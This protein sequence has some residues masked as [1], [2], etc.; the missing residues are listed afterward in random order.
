MEICFNHNYLE[1]HINNEYKGDIEYYKSFSE[2]HVKDNL[3]EIELTSQVIYDSLLRTEKG[4]LCI[5]DNKYYSPFLIKWNNETDSPFIFY[6]C[7]KEEPFII[8]QG[9]VYATLHWYYEVKTNMLIRNESRSGEERDTYIIKRCLADILKH[10]KNPSLDLI[11]PK[12]RFYYFGF[13][14]NIGHQ[15]WNE[16]SGLLYLI[17]NEELLKNISKIIIGPVDFFG[18]EKV[19]KDKNISTEVWKGNRE[20]FVDHIPI[21]THMSYIPNDITKLFNIPKRDKNKNEIV[22]TIDIRS[23]RRV[24]DN[25]CEWYSYLINRVHK[26]FP[27]KKIKLNF[28]GNFVSLHKGAI[29]NMEEIGQQEAVRED[30]INNVHRDIEMNN[31]IGSNIL[32]C[33]EEACNSD[34]CLA[35]LGTSISNLSNWIFRNKV[36]FYGPSACYC[37]QPIQSNIMNNKEGIFLPI[38]FII[39]EPNNRESNYNLKYEE[40]SDFVIKELQIE[41]DKK[42]NRCL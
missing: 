27:D 26:T 42:R 29:P 40:A 4:F 30:I 16:V 35:T 6:V 19:L 1:Q 37:W 39:S 22:L 41:I 33:F 12:K 20:S 38:E 17:H 31:L 21:K 24:L 15:L 23:Y 28:C 32:E 3:K 11:T 18:M 25:Q 2:G 14:T 9:W 8:I 5:K 13:I 10:L 36:I 34:L 7:K